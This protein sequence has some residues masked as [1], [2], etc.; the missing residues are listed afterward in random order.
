VSRRL[1]ARQGG[2]A[3][4]TLMLTKKSHTLGSVYLWLNTCFVGFRPIPK[5]NT[6]DFSANGNLHWRI[7]QFVVDLA[8]R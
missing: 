6:P 4:T 8:N 2:T 1:A 3:A 7:Y 5:D